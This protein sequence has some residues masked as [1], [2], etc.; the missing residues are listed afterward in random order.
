VVLTVTAYSIFIA[1]LPVSH[2]SIS[3][4]TIGVVFGAGITKSG[5]PSIALKFRL[6]KSIDLYRDKKIRMIF[7]SGL[8]AEAAVMKNYLLKKGIPATCI[9]PDEKGETTFI[10]VE[11]VRNYIQNYNITDGA[12]FISQRYHLPR[13]MFIVR[14]LKIENSEFIAAEPN[15]INILEGFLAVFR[16]TFA[17]LKN[18]FFDQDL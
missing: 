5:E 2:D 8:S 18:I 17:W 10:T 11:N 12:A 9:L 14:K 1:L 15:R 7:V 4:H 13:I 6:D 16:E 3:S